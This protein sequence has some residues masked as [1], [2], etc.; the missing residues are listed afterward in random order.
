MD[1]RQAMKTPILTTLLI[2]AC[3][4]MPLDAQAQGKP[5][6]ASSGLERDAGNHHNRWVGGLAALVLA[7]VAVAGRRKT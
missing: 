1:V 7:G 5:V 3:G 2:L 6:S 4:L